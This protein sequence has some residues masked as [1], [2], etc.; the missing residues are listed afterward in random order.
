[1]GNIPANTPMKCE[2]CNNLMKIFEEKQFIMLLAQN[3]Q[4]QMIFN[5][6][7]Y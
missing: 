3:L 6:K 4:K 7:N 1:M 5:Q 2:K